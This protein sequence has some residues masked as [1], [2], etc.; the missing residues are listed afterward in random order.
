MNSFGP[1]MTLA[2]ELIEKGEKDAVLQYLDLCAKFWKSGKESPDGGEL[3]KW[4]AQVRKGELPNFGANL[5]Y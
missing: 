2:K 5:W 4:K 3:E 1:N